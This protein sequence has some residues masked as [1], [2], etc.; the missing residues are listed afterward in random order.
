MMLKQ[1]RVRIIVSSLVIL[2]PILF[3]LVM[4]NELPSSMITHWGADANADGVGN[5]A[6]AVF[7]LPL[8]LLALHLICLLFTLLDKKQEKQNKKALGMVF[9]IVPFLSLYTNGLNYSFALGKELDLQLALPTLIGI[10]F[11]FM[12]NYLP[13]VTQNQTLGI[14]LPWTLGNEQNWNKTHRLCGKL[15]VVGGLILIFSAFLPLEVMISALI[16]VLL[17]LAVVPIAYSYYIYKQHQEQGVA[18]ALAPKSRA[19]RITSRVVSVIIALFLISIAVLMF[20]GKIEATCGDSSISIDASYWADLKLDYSRIESIEYRTDL[21]AG[22]RTNGF[23]SAKLSL[24]SF[25]NTELGKYTRFA[26]TGASECIVIKSGA[27]T[28]VIGLKTPEA[29][30]ALYDEISAKVAK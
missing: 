27:N 4:W 16:A 9:W 14:K 23:A 19:E 2:L 28:L 25:Q 26:Y 15:W 10:I 6:F 29:T 20:S 30:R 5:K 12:G 24:G 8:I 22:T 3:G 1:Y 7:G 11:V 13:K 21:K 18:Y 17:A